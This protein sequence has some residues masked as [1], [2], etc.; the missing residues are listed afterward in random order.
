[1]AE[2][3]HVQKLG[4]G[5]FGEV[6]LCH[7]AALAVPRAVKFIPAAN[8]ADPN[9]FYAEARLLE[10]LQ[11]ENVVRVCD[12]GPYQGGVYIAMEYLRY[13]SAADERD[14]AGLVPIRRSRSLIA[15]ALRG[16]EYLHLRDHIH[17][18]IKPGN[19]MVGDAGRA[20]LA[21]FGLVT[22]LSSDGRAQLGLG[23]EFHLAP[24]TWEL[25]ELTT[26]TDVYA[27]GLTL[28]RL[29][30]GDSA[31]PQLRG[32]DLRDAVMA[33]TFIARDAFL[34][35]VTRRMR[36]VIQK[37]IATDPSDRYQSAA[38]FRH[39]L[40][41]VPILGDWTWTSN[42]AGEAVWH[43]ESETH[44]AEVSVEIVSKREVTVTTRHRPLG[45]KWRRCVRHCGRI[46]RGK[47]TSHLR[48][49]LSEFT[50]AGHF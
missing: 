8:V 1:M 23:Y 21:D 32:N 26:L 17:C 41:Q 33:G 42:E 5:S 14:T 44:S 28:F 30:N 2:Y 46:P 7:D 43:G 6:W 15:E 39:A 29:V 45:G 22:Q 48:V 40:E 19:I 3:Q 38:D 20:K 50:E 49:A 37:A 36:T 34:P 35:F 27:A 10:Q 25:G 18:D 47:L 11:H 31:L 13:G 24:E 16:L 4:S 12:A 9:D